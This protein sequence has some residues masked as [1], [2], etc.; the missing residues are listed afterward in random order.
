MKKIAFLAPDK[1]KSTEIEAI[2]SDFQAEII[3]EIGSLDEGL[4][5]AKRLIKQGIEIIIARGET[6]LNIRAVHPNIVVLD[7]P[8]SGFDLVLAL[9][10]ARQY[11]SNIAVVS[12]PSM[13]KQIES[14]E[15]ALGVKI[16]KY[17]LTTRDSV[18]SMIELAMHD[19]AAVILGGFTTVVAAKKKELP[20]VQIKTGTQAYVD[21]FFS[22][23]SILTSIELEKRRMGLIQTVLNHVYDGIIS[24]D[25]KC[26]ITTFNPVAQRIF[27]CTGE[28]GS[29]IDE[30]CP[31]IGLES[32][33]CNGKEELNNIYKVHDIQ[34][35]CNKVPIKDGKKIIGAIATFQDITK[36]QMME[37]RIRKEAYIKGHI[38]NSQFKDIY[39]T[40]KATA[41]TIAM[42]KSF[43]VTE[44]NVLITGE[45][46]TG[47]EVFAQSIHNNSRRATGPFVA[48]NCAA[49]P[50][51]LL[52]S[53]LFGYVSGAFT[54]ANKEGKAGLFEVAHGG[55]IFLDE[56]GEMD[57]A[58]Q[59]RLLRVLQE[60]NVV[61]LGSDKV[62]PVDVRIIAATNKDLS[63]LVAANKFREDL[64]YRL[65]VLYLQIPPLRDRQKD[66]SVYAKQFMKE[67]AQGKKLDFSTGALKLLENHTWPGNIRE[68]RNI[69]ERIVAMSQRDKI[70]TSFVKKIMGLE[71]TPRTSDEDG[72]EVTP[73]KEA[74]KACNGKI[75]DAAKALG[76]SRS[77]LWRRMTRLGIRIC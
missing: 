11:G 8:I 25:E 3:F 2:L 49:L 61:R 54:G 51:Q 42:A 76:V 40:S 27:R 29:K 33:L 63:E 66:V 57:V 30:I 38:A 15:S 12:F 23:K 5:K 14:L 24:V 7:V 73:I 75:S 72:Q 43:S 28:I 77:T 58:N 6:A 69:I 68:L 35:L 50:A 32:I 48:I 67:L 59:S 13:I 56:I 22:A 18:N 9:E 71:I 52:E 44:A 45:T 62:L 34:I 26:R 53:E 10:E 19:G 4:V 55:T 46:G 64:F 17:H 65:N 20:C 70:S 16:K 47:K 60:K 74:L 41:A 37:A 39:G 31:E 1:N 36:I 21:A